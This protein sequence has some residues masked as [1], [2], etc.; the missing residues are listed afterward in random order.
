MIEVVALAGAL[1]HAGENGET[2]TRF[3]DVV[4]EL[5][6]VDSFADTGAAE[7]AHLA[8]LGERAH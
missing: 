4:D 2:R 8:A 7:Q 1:A 5:Q 3:C 6:H